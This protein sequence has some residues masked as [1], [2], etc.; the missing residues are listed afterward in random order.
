M[1]F[2]SANDRPQE[3]ADL[4][5]IE[6]YGM[7]LKSD[8]AV[9]SACETGMGTLHKGEGIM[10][11]SRAFAYAGVPAAIISLWKVPDKATSMIMVKFYTYLK[12]GHRKDVALQLAKTEFV[13]EYPQMSHP[14]YWSGFVLTGN[15]KEIPFPT[16]AWMW[17]A[18]AITFGGGVL[19]IVFWRLKIRKH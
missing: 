6:L 8:L 12:E 9:L 1:M 4:F 10:S 13:K 14:F 7:Q 5:A 19:V 16:V 15:N 18:I 17:W 11:F 3:T 2:A